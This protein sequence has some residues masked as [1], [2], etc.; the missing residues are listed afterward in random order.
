MLE[1]ERDEKA[2]QARASLTALA[3]ARARILEADLKGTGLPRCDYRR[4]L[5]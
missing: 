1:E 2:V 3:D 4:I 5:V